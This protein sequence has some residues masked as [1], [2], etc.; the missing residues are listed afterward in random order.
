MSQAL[1]GPKGQ[2]GGRLRTAI[3]AGAAVLA[4][5]AAAQAATITY[6]FEGVGQGDLNGAA[7]NGDFTVTLVGDTTTVT[8]GVGQLINDAT[9]A[10]F[11]SGALS[12]TLTGLGN[13]VRVNTDPTIFPALI[14]GQT[15]PAPTFFVAEGTVNPVFGA[16]DLASNL[17]LTS[18]S[19]TA[20]PQTFLTSSGDLDFTNISA[21]SFE[22]VV[23]GVPEPGSW[24]LM[25]IG[26]GGLGGALRLNR[27][28]AKAAATA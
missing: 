7:F 25:L 1:A 20:I 13:S 16:Y 22:A 23:A 24:A 3:L 9:S 8:T 27:R 28:Q 11:S 4:F 21:L 15:Q 2:G 26:V 19:V 14:F 6:T 5:G 18:G 10:S 12:A 17:A